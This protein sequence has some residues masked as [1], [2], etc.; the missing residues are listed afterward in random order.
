MSYFK[1][2]LCRMIHRFIMKCHF[3]TN[4]CLCL[5]MIETLGDWDGAMRVVFG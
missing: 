4:V 1:K 3:R 5:W 2:G